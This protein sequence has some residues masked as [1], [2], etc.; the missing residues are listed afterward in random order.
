MPFFAPLPEPEPEPES[1]AARRFY[2]F[3]WQ[4]PEHVL[5]GLGPAGLARTA[6]TALQLAVVGVYPQ[7]L[8]LAVRARFHPDHLDDPWGPPRRAVGPMDDLRFGLQWPDGSRAEVDEPHDGQDPSGYRLAIPRGGG[9][10]LG[11]DWGLWLWPLPPPERVTAH[12][13]WERRGIPETAAEL[14]LAPIIPW[15]AGSVELWP[16]PDPPP[17]GVWRANA[18]LA[19]DRP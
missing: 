19:R 1:D 17:E 14:D 4:E 12:V 10:E 13:M 5:A 18:P 9:W 8:A 11:Y 16:L 2:A 15:A 3:P 7:G 6:T